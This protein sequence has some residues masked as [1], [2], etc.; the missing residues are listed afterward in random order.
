MFMNIAINGFGRIGRAVFKILLDKKRNINIV[1]INDLADTK[2]LAHLLKHDSCYEKYQKTVNSVADNLVVNNKKYKVLSEK[3]PAKLPWHKMG[4]DIVLECT[5]RFRTKKEAELHLKA[6]AK[7]VIIS[8]PA[9]D[10][11]IKTVVFGVNENEIKKTDKIISMASCTTNCLAPVMKIIEDN[12]GIQK[13]V[14][15]TTHSYT[16]DQNIVDS[17]H[18][19]FYRA[20]AGAVNI[21]PTTTGAAVATAKIMPQLNNK[22]DGMAIRVPTPV[23]S[24]CDIV[25][26][27][28]TKTDEQTVKQFIKKAI[29][30]KCY[31]NII[32][33]TEEPLV[34]SDFIGDPASAIIALPLIK[35]IDKDL[36]KI[37][38]W[39]DN[40]WGYSNRLVELCE[41][42]E[43]TL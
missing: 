14:M 13:A 36:L 8:A 40:E 30:K 31:K 6:G 22:F 32:K 43:K 1:A 21:I 15:T 2:I 37:I 25:C 29:F 35:V 4:V 19:D 10:E 26:V 33:T 41:H 39:Y 34:S 23:V 28:K 5:G 24:L 38:A 7:K 42:V 16:A 20:R 3:N 12:F 9:K 11:N 17:P 27:L 18:K